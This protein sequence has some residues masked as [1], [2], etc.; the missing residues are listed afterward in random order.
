MALCSMRSLFC[1]DDVQQAAVDQVDVHA[2]M[3]IFLHVAQWRL[4]AGN[5]R[6]DEV[7]AV[8][9]LPDRGRQRRIHQEKCIGAATFRARLRLVAAAMR[10]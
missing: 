2:K 6:L 10:S 9:Q 4:D 8:K 1:L 7:T 5:L 3:V